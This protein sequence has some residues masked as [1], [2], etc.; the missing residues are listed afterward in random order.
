VIRQAAVLAAAA[1]VIVAG[2]EITSWLLSGTDALPARFGPE[3]CRRVALIDARTGWRISGGEDLA[4]TRGGDEVI[5]SAHDRHDPARPD[6]GLYAVPIRDLAAAGPAEA[7]A[8]RPLVDLAARDAP[9][10]PHG[11]ALSPDGERLALVNRV[12]SREAVVEIGRLNGSGWRPEVVVRDPALC[13]ANDLAFEDE[14]GGDAIAVTIDRAD[15]A[16]SVRDLVPGTRTGSVARIE[17]GALR[18]VRTGLGFPNGI[19]AGGVAETRRDRL[20]RPDGTAVPLSGS[21]DNLTADGD[22][23]VVAVHTDLMRLWFHARGWVGSAPSR[24]VRVAADDTVETLFD[25]P[26]GALFSGATVGL[27]AGGGLIAGAAR[28]AGLLV[29]GDPA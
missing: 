3:D 24:I 12:A 29:C 22:A 25:D 8:A 5:V 1:L 2:V 18:T 6:G 7:V 13:R 9:F 20:L 28:D 26:S 23:L 10:R 15:C 19:A 17:D 16:N 21:P 14:A 4:L 11:I 27:L